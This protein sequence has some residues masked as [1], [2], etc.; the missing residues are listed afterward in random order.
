LAHGLFDAA[1]KSRIQ[2]FFL[3]QK[4]VPQSAKA[5]IALWTG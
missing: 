2:P 5:D 3:V 4:A 1:L